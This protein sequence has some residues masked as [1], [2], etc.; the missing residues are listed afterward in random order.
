MTPHFTQKKSKTTEFLTRLYL[1]QSFP[2][3]LL[4]LFLISSTIPTHN[5]EKYKISMFIGC[6]RFNSKCS[7][8]HLTVLLPHWNH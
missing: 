4:Y 2:P 6:N 3:S 1:I 5:T 8:Y 7:T